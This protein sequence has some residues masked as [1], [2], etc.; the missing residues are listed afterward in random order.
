MRLTG[1]LLVTCA[2][3]GVACRERAARFM[4]VDAA[5]P[6]PEPRAE[7]PRQVH[8]TFT[9]PTSVTFSWV[10]SARSIRLWSRNEPPRIVEAHEP[11]P[12]PLGPGR[13][14]EAAVT[15][16]RPDT[17]YG[18]QVGRPRQPVP[19]FF[20]TPPAPG[21]SKFTFAAV[22]DLGASIDYPEVNQIHRLVALGEPA[23]VLALGGLTYADVRS[24]SSVD[25]HFEDVMAW[26]KRAAYMPVWGEHEWASETRDDL[27]N[28][29]GRFA[30]P[31]PQTSPGA[32]AVGCCGEDWSWF[33][34]GNVRFIAYP[35]P[36]TDATW[37]DWAAKA[38]PLFEEA[39]ATAALELV[40]TMGH[41]P[42]YSSS[43]EGG[44]AR[45]R[46][47]LDGFGARFRKYVLNL[48]GHGHVYERTKP[49]AH[50]VHVTV[51]SGGAQLAHV[52]NWC[53]W[54]EC[55]PP[56]F[57]AF[58]AIH[59]GMLRLSSRPGGLKIE[60]FC[61]AATPARD[62]VRCAEGEML[63][64]FTIEVAPVTAAKQR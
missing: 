51:P 62:D 44:D 4:G 58:R 26:S 12:K 45:L 5:P 50:V 29:K 43:P 18:Y 61:G 22:A 53:S 57:S 8:F 13:W 32:P 48:S 30:L 17:E 11:S 19:A 55:K 9:G 40:V 42:A 64:N 38:A 3:L 2:L 36:Y 33:D 39:E 46:R 34:Y 23:F 28:Y 41:R 31:H 16:L 63:E 37:D 56:A 7:E 14:Q 21:A 27:R 52:A 59:L 60:A 6:V 1:A 47:L 25:R 35:E 49:Q 10:G 54:K 15:D 24:Q 20:R